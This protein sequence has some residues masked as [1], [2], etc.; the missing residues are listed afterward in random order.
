MEHGLSPAE[1][2]PTD[3][4][5]SP[6]HPVLLLQVAVESLDECCPLITN[7]TSPGFVVLVVSVHVVHQPS[8]P[9][10]LFVAELTDAEGLDTRGDFL[11]GCVT[12]L[13]GFGFLAA[14]ADGSPSL[15]Q[16]CKWRGGS[17]HLAAVGTS[18]SSLESRLSWSQ[19]VVARTLPGHN[20]GERVADLNMTG[21]SY[22]SPTLLSPSS[23][24]EHLR[25]QIQI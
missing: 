6:S 12:H 24:G 11:L 1:N 23:R 9:T 4:T 16:L 13:S 17:H 7:V 19:S 3:W 20:P 2:L 10:A 22:S 21:Q 25:S 5:R 14:P 8:E 15:P 18:P